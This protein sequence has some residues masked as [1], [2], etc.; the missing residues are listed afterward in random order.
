MEIVC[1]NGSQSPSHDALMKPR[2][3]IVR[4]KFLNRYEMQF[5]EPLTAWFDITAFGSL[6]PFHDQFA[7]PMVKLPS[8]M[9]FP[10]FPYK[11][12]VFNRL[13]TDAHYLL[14][15]ESHLSGFDLVH[16]AETY[17]R[18]TQQCLNAKKQ[19]R[20]KKVI[21][22]VL[23][24]IPFHN[25]GI[26]GRAEYKERARRE[27][28]HLIALSTLTKKTLIEE[29]TDPKKISV[30]HH[31]VDTNVFH[32]NKNWTKKLQSS[33]K[34]ITLLFT[35]R[36]EE[37]KGVLDILSALHVLETDPDLHQF[38]LH[39]RFVGEGSLR[40]ILMRQTYERRKLWH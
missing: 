30:I 17:Y 21:A 32:P 15:L 26:H 7:F 36:L 14:G 19:G 34:N 35:G 4:G 31:Y 28:D 38:H 2:V 6:H 25:E 9:D 11:M 13:F 8:P 29:G 24:T 12:P 5:F 37:Y 33:L 27:L 16:T 1:R 23:E 10:E 22:T 3:A 18:Y 39:V 20:V 40:N